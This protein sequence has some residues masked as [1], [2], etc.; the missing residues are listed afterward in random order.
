M[1]T[2][3]IKNLKRTSSE[4]IL[5]NQTELVAIDQLNWPDYQYKP[6]VKFR[7]GHDGRNILLKFYVHEKSIRAEASETNGDVYKDSCVEFFISP[8]ADGW[9]YNFEFSCIGTRHVGY[10]N[11]RHNRVPVP[12]EIVE[13]IKVSST[14]GSKP[15][16][17]KQGD[18]KWELFVKIPISCFI[19]DD[20]TSFEGMGAKGNFYKCGDELA[21]P[22]FITWNPVK[23][24]N[25]DYHQH[26]YF[27]DLLF[28]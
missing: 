21:E 10:G 15:F 16:S 7:I 22:H 3:T 24:K 4:I 5:E 19:H 23:T 20:F 1:Q 27:S 9:Y 17:E 26:Q 12:K 13:N 25:P 11:G 28:E 18:F 6:E 2:L 8:H 14:L